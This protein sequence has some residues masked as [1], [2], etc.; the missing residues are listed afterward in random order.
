MAID[1]TDL[2]LVTARVHCCRLGAA[3]LGFTPYD[4]KG[5]GSP[6]PCEY[7][8]REIQ[9][10]TTQWTLITEGTVCGKR[11]VAN[12]TYSGEVTP[13]DPPVADFSGETIA[14]GGVGEGVGSFTDLTAG[15]TPP[16]VTYAWDFGD[17]DPGDTSADQNPTYT[18]DDSVSPGA[19]SHVFTVTLTVTDSAGQSDSVQHDVEIF[20][21]QP[22]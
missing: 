1:S 11:P 14:G 6:Y 7:I 22:I 21:N 13:G 20:F 12:F 18:Y 15:G 5:P 9:P 17:D 19:I 16:Y 2:A 10:P 3:R 4:V 8:W